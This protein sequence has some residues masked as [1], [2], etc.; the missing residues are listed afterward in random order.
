MKPP[1][2]SI[3]AFRYLAGGQKRS[4]QTRRLL[5]GTNL[6]SSKT[7]V[8]ALLATH[9]LLLL[10]GIRCH[11]A[12][13]NEVAHVPAGLAVWETGTFTLYRVNPPL[14]RMLAVLPVLAAQPRTDFADLSDAP[15]LRQEW[16]AAH[17]FSDLNA[18]NYMDLIRLARLAGVAWS[19]LG[20]WLVYRWA[21]ELYGRRA[22]L[23]GLT[24]WCFEPNII[25]HAQLVTPDIPATVSGLAAPMCFGVT[26][27]A[28]IGTMP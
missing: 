5:D 4:S 22:G 25:A 2:H 27:D 26:C 6:L 11:F 8:V 20:G 28:A 23:L 18:H 14:W 19:L 17:R 1:Q 9:A 12:T 13:R 15:E 16:E 10:Y 21:G 24:L 3:E 7:I